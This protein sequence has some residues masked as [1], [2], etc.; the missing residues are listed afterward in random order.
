MEELTA[1]GLTVTPGQME[2]DILCCKVE[3]KKSIKLPLSKHFLQVDQKKLNA[4]TNGATFLTLV[5]L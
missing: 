5:Y 4:Q 1:I 2:V 3:K